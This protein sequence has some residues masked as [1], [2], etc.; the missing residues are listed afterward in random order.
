MLK[1][2]SNIVANIVIGFSNT[3]VCFLNINGL[4]IAQIPNIKNKFDILLPTTFPIAMSECPS[5]DAVAL[6]N[7]SGIDVP[8]ATIVSPI[9]ISGI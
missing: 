4:I 5:T 1:N 9:T 2:N 7:I 3:F 6:T 8:I